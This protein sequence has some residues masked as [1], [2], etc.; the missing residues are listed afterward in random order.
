MW[1][2]TIGTAV[3][4]VTFDDS[5]ERWGT[6]AFAADPAVTTPGWTNPDAR[7]FQWVFRDFEPTQDAESGRSAY[8]IRLGF[9]KPTWTPVD[10]SEQYDVE[11][12]KPNPNDDF[13]P[14]SRYERLWQR[15]FIADVSQAD[16]VRDMSE[17]EFSPFAQS[18]SPFWNGPSQ[19]WAV[20]GNGAKT[21]FAVKL[22]GAEHVGELRIVPG[23]ADETYRGY[24]RPR[25]IVATF[26]DG[27]RKTLH[28][29]D[30]PRMQRFPVDVVTSIVRFRVSSLYRGAKDPAVV[31][32]A[33][34]DVGP[35]SSPKWL[36]FADALRL[37]NP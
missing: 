34:A 30:E 35:T 26:S 12:A 1:Q 28:I 20:R 16:P 32:V 22:R 29:A 3:V 6:D 33:L 24:S 27:S 25:T 31:A 15:S 18:G 7:T 2:G 5:C 9:A 8:D 36:A 10:S 17:Y 21:W 14:T 11:Q 19:A 13:E 4:R 23:V 37:A